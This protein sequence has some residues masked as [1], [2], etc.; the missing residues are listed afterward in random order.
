MPLFFV[1]L[2]QVW[3]DVPDERGR[4]GNSSLGRSGILPFCPSARRE[5]VRLMGSGHV[6]KA[7][8]ARGR[9]QHQHPKRSQ[10]YP[11]HGSK[12]LWHGGPEGEV[13]S[14]DG[15]SV[16]SEYKEL[17]RPRIS[18]HKIRY[19]NRKDQILEL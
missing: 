17:V 10:V 19:H 15:R 13:A 9:G 8:R 12:A 6:R 11:K 2:T 3:K 18:R 14:L 7:F 4:S 16:S 1:L 5:A